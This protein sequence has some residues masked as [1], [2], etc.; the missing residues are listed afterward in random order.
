MALPL[1]RLSPW[2]T[3][4]RQAAVLTDFDGT[5]APIVVDPAKAVPLPGVPASLASLA[6]RYARVAVISGRP[7]AYLVEHLG[8]E[9]DLDGVT[10]VGLYGLERVRGGRVEEVGAAARWR[11][12]V[13]Q[14][15]RAAARE[16]PAG[17]GVEHKGLAV[18]LHVRAAPER[19]GWVGSWAAAEAA[20]SGLVAHPG[21]MSVELRPPLDTDKGTVVTELAGGLDAV[22]YFGDD[23]GDLPAFAALSRMS[24]AGRDVLAVAVRSDESPAELLAAADLVVEGPAGVLG[25]LQALARTR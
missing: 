16:A 15:A 25:V 1:D 9:A 21:R 4:P 11:P 8:G 18:T 10:L 24:Q 2:L 17:V 22:C 5:I 7:V 3:R 12:V 13:D 6:A 23:R 14:V 20:A 19:Q